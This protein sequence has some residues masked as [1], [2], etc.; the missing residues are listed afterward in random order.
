MLDKFSDISY[1]TR[2]K[3]LGLAYLRVLGG[4]G[5]GNFGHAGRPGEVGGSASGTG[6][7]HVYNIS[8]RQWASPQIH[9]PYEYD[10]LGQVK[11]EALEVIAEVPTIRGLP[12][13]MRKRG[14]TYYLSDSSKRKIIGEATVRDG[15]IISFKAVSEDVV[16]KE[17]V[18]KRF[19][20]LVEF[21]ESLTP[22]TVSTPNEFT[23][24]WDTEHIRK[25]GQQVSDLID[26][27]GV[28]WL[29][30]LVKR[31]GAKKF[32]AAGGSGS[33][34]FGHAGRPGEVGGSSPGVAHDYYKVGY[35]E[36]LQRGYESDYGPHTRPY[37]SN[38]L[39]AIEKADG[40][41]TYNPV[42]GEQPTT[43]FALSI[44]PERE[45]KIDGSKADVVALAEYAAKN[46]D[47]LS[48]PQ[49]YMGGWHSPDDGQV[50]LDVS[51][52]VQT[53]EEA[54]RLAREANQLAYFD[55]VKGQSI[56][57]E[58]RTPDVKAARA[59]SDRSDRWSSDFG[60]SYRARSSIDRSRT[61]SGRN[62]KSPSNSLP[63]TV[64]TLGG[65]GSGNFNHAGRPGQV[66]G[67][68]ADPGVSG[69]TPELTTRRYDSARIT[70]P[71]KPI[72]AVHAAVQAHGYRAITTKD[73]PTRSLN[74]ITQAGGMSSPPIDTTDV[75]AAMADGVVQ[76][77]EG[78]KGTRA[79]AV[80]RNRT[81]IAFVNYPERAQATTATLDAQGNGYMMINTNPQ[82][83]ADAHDPSVQ[84]NTTAGILAQDKGLTGAAF[85]REYYKHVFTHEVGHVID[86]SVQGELLHD[87][88]KDVFAHTGQDSDRLFNFLEKISPYSTANAGEGFAEF[89][90]MTAAG[91]TIPGLEDLQR[92]IRDN[93]L[94]SYR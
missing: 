67:S 68:A 38:V 66:G 2:L 14:D 93:Y 24:V 60:R 79:E 49:N 40:G 1:E 71:T 92:R 6:T 30:E 26:Q 33:G 9:K 28:D 87:F 17:A 32:K 34:N 73:I 64:T 12:Y 77:M 20:E 63:T 94:K 48:Q 74:A 15:Q 3:L 69:G 53:A 31:Q 78:L 81:P 91:K 61:D 21:N 82:A 76:G 70:G 47:L 84:R 10:P 45:Q 37:P 75:S 62:R 13:E 36:R 11:R 5:S 22:R 72:T 18:Q 85:D 83:L 42:T 90:T 89:F 46:W 51:T 58:Y 44:H 54:E 23:D 52:V 25:V 57:L 55:L 35:R 80:T 39:A 86:A 27:Y 19:V 41:F 8:T 4:P 56:K 7:T 88:V 29:G 43:G 16:D 65:P 50:Y 59:Q